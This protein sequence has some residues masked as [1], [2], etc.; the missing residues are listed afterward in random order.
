MIK[1]IDKLLADSCWDFWV[2]RSDN[3]GRRS[4]L[5]RRVFACPKHI[6]ERRA[7][8]DRRDRIDR[9]CDIDQSSRADRRMGARHA[10]DAHEH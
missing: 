5:D 3:G 8:K 1:D 9:R 10:K 7:G 4:G 6:P 2:S